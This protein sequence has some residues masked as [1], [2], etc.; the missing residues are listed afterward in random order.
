MNL[1]VDCPI[2]LILMRR[3]IY[4]SFELVVRVDGLSDLLERSY[5]EFLVWCCRFVR[6][7]CLV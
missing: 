5:L 4:S 7:N 2:Q 3:V 6:A 1:Q